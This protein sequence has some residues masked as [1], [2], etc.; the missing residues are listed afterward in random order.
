[1]VERVRRDRNPIRNPN[2]APPPSTRIEFNSVPPVVYRMQPLFP[3]AIHEWPF[4]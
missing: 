3:I 2:Y 4:L 1:M